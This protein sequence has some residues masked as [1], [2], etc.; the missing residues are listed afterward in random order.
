MQIIT[1]TIGRGAEDKALKGSDW[2]A[3]RVSTMKALKAFDHQAVEAH[4]GW[5]VW[6]GETEESFKATILRDLPM[7]V[8]DLKRLKAELA[9]LAEKFEQDAIALTVGESELIS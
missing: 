8:W 6:Q 3:F 2:H 4:K 9:T 7:S 1:V 5:G